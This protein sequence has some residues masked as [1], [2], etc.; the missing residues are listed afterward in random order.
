VRRLI[1]HLSDL[2]AKAV[3]T[4]ALDGFL[5][6]LRRFP[7]TRRP[8]IMKLGF[9]EIVDRF[10]DDEDFATLANK[11]IR[12]KWFGSYSR[13]FGYALSREIVAK[14]PVIASM[15]KKKDDVEREREAWDGQQ[16]KTMFATPL[17]T[18]AADLKAYREQPGTLLAHDAKYWLP[19]VALWSGMR[20]DELGAMRADELRCE[21]GVWIFDLTKRPLRGYRRVKNAQ[22]Q[23]T[24]PLHPKL[25]ELGFVRYAAAQGEWLF[26]DL[27]H[28]EK[29]ET[30]TTAA[31][32]KWFG[33]W[34]RA[35]GFYEA[36][37]IQDFHS[38]RHSFKDACREAGLA[39]DVHDR[40]T[41]HAG[42]ANQQV[43][44]KY[45]TGGSQRFLADAMA[46]VSF[47]TFPKLAAYDLAEQTT[48]PVLA[49]TRGRSEA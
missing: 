36:G 31:V 22:S 3:T 37:R 18:G 2:P 44:R 48:R 8:E 42:A 35:N 38:Y 21:A 11:T 20:L 1:E 29:D 24:V 26:P 4:V 14:N 12:A 15:P 40:L 27:P 41:G 7:N 49:F 19:V 17:F 13:L 6:K 5:A 32:S 9:D 39:E 16:I 33:L 10:G 43:S 34:R 45:G 46:K 23:R 25:V 28:D 30:A 47:P